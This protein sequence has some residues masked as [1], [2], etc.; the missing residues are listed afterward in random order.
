MKLRTIILFITISVAAFFTSCQNGEKKIKM[1]VINPTVYNFNFPFDS[2]RKV[3]I[4]SLNY[5]KFKSSAEKEKKSNEF[6]SGTLF[7]ETKNN[8]AFA[9]DFFKKAE[10][11][12]DVYLHSYDVFPSAVYYSKDCATPLEFNAEYQIKLE[13]I[14]DTITKVSIITLNYKV[15]TGYQRIPEPGM[16][17]FWKPPIECDLPVTTV[18]E[19]ELLLKIGQSLGVKNMPKIKI[20]AKIC[21]TRKGKVI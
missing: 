3:I 6:S 21:L 2:V 8:A 5:Y 11:K 19:Y 14:R 18:E 15:I 9:E 10:N 4:S 20:P 16:C 17:G 1:S 7:L 12:N 13:K